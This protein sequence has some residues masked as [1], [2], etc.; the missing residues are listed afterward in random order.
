MRDS[1][2]KRPEQ[3][4]AVKWLKDVCVPSVSDK[5]GER[6]MEE[7]KDHATES[8]CPTKPVEAQKSQAP[9]AR[10]CPTCKWD[11]NFE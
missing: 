2:R 3:V 7:K 5:T 10:V 8:K 6:K 9:T 11:R 4:K 1:K